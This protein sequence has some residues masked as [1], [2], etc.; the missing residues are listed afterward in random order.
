MKFNHIGIFVKDIEEGREEISKLCWEQFT[1]N[2]CAET[3]KNE[4]EKNI[5]EYS[6]EKEKSSKK[7]YEIIEKYA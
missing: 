4:I 3:T 5:K 6:N 2:E 1:G 7:I